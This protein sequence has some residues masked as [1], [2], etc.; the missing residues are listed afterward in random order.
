MMIV[1]HVESAVT[2]TAEM[3]TMSSMTEKQTESSIMCSLEFNLRLD[4][5]VLISEQ[6]VNSSALIKYYTSGGSEVRTSIRSEVTRHWSTLLFEDSD[7]PQTQSEGSL[8]EL[9]LKELQ[10]CQCKAFLEADQA[11]LT[12]EE[13]IIS[14]KGVAKQISNDHRPSNVQEK[15]R[16]EELGGYFADG[17]LNG[18]L[19]VTLEPWRQNT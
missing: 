19:A 16:V 17:Y 6:F 8:D 3:R 14:R 10:E 2:T 7:L 18:E 1:S 15:K 9:F 4:D 12:N 13:C 11:L 5:V